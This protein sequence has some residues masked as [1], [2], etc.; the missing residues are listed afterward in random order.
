MPS[1]AS[2]SAGRLSIGE[3]VMRLSSPPTAGYATLQTKSEPGLT[4]PFMRSDPP[5][6]G[7]LWRAGR[8]QRG[9]DV[10]TTKMA[11]V[12]TIWIGL[13]AVSAST[14]EPHSKANAKTSTAARGTEVSEV[15]VTASMTIPHVQS[16]FPALGSKIAPGL[17]VIRVTYDAR[18]RPDGWAYAREAGLDYPD[19]ASSPRLLDD[20]R[21][22]VVI[23]RTLPSKTYAIWFNRPP[24]QDFASLSRRPAGAYELRFTTT[25]DDPVRTLPEAM[26]A[27]PALSRVANPVE[28]DG[29]AIYGQPRQPPGGT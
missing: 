27:D 14:A 23:C 17:V 11:V 3:T 6:L 13:V 26:K 15:T 2:A 16:T 10:L 7:Q 9:G 18:M 28:P 25:D 19:C 1:V 24:L 20:G 4:V 5:Q 29:V 21:S 8:V 22:F 12:A